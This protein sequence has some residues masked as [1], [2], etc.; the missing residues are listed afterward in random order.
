MLTEKLV[1][2]LFEGPDM[3]DFDNALYE[4]GNDFAWDVPQLTIS[5]TAAEASK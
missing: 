5:M 4:C 2:T 3:S 1:G